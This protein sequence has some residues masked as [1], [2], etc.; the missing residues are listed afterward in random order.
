[1]F[2]HLKENKQLEFAEK[3]IEKTEYWDID[4]FLE[5]LIFEK[6]VEWLL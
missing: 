6:P 3:Q 5:S 2:E 1:L 4:Y